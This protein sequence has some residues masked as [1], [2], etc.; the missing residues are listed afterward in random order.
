MLHWVDPEDGHI[1]DVH[2]ARYAIDLET[3]VEAYS[4]IYPWGDGRNRGMVNEITGYL[5]CHALGIP[6][7][8]RAF[9][10][11]VPLREICTPDSSPMIRQLAEQ[12]AY[13]PA[14]CTQRLDGKSAAY[15]LPRVALPGLI[16]DVKAWDKLPTTMAVDDQI[17]NVD[18]HL[19]NLIRLG[20]KSFAVID[21]GI[22]AAAPR[23]GVHH[24]T[25]D[26]LDALALFRN[27]L[28]EHVFNQDPPN[29]VVSATLGEAQNC[30]PAVDS[31]IDELE[32]WW[33]QLLSGEDYE[34][35]KAFI[36]ERTSQIEVILR[37]RYNRLL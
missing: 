26:R 6:Q 20:S 34:K 15:R 5:V 24:W 29:K 31:V 35:F 8:A 17:A 36:L 11:Y 14:F 4:K 10:A 16:E 23:E 37:R 30:A 33:S 1:S 2:V 13:Y 9:V 21:N 19:N 3:S 22:L 28:C 18:R 32:F 7:P 12:R 27:R 25:V